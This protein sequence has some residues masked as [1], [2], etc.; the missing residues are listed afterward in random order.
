M[1]WINHVNTD[2]VM[3][4]ATK[5]R[6]DPKAVRRTMKLE[7]IWVFENDQPQFVTELAYEKGKQRIEVDSPI[8]MGGSGSRLGPMQYCITG[9]ASC[10]LSTV[11]TVATIKDVKLKSAKILAECNLNFGKTFDISN[12]PIVD[13][14][15]FKV[16]IEGDADREKLTSIIKEAEQK[17]PAVYSLAH[18]I[19][20]NA[21]L[22]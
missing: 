1:P 15:S 19:N 16:F 21:T 13:S 8:F 11:V 12:D 3:D 17:C 7:G 9:I 2:Q 6:S 14:V 22:V 18:Q 10:F 20:V 4:T 5:G